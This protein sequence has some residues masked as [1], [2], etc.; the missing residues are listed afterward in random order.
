M[1]DK[2]AL[3]L[4]RLKQNKGLGNVFL[5]TN[6]VVT[7]NLGPDGSSHPP[8]VSTERIAN[9]TAKTPH[10]ASSTG[11]RRKRATF[12]EPGSRAQTSRVFRTRAA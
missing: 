12:A 8:G 2:R 9:A 10:E 6:N 3:A 7:R 5:A 1:T 4:F 11:S